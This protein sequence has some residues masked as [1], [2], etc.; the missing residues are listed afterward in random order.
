MK[1]FF[2]IAFVVFCMC[3]VAYLIDTYQTMSVGR[4]V[5][6]LF[7]IGILSS[8]MTVYLANFIHSVAKEKQKEEEVE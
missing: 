6:N 7:F 1:N 4:F 3:D 8:A 2:D 5:L